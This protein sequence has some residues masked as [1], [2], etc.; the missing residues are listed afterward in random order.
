[1]IK[2]RNYRHKFGAKRTEVDQIK[3][4]SKIEAKY[5]QKLK[6]LQ[7]SGELLFF[8][9][10]PMF[11]LPGGVTYR[12]DFIEFYAD[13]KIVISDVKGVETE[14]FRIKKKMV[15]DIYPIDIK[16]VKRV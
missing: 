3:F 8:L 6:M 11:D 2:W 4:P 5:Y 10:Q 16:V 7:K 13:G 12:A 9:R 15:E 1:M 14:T